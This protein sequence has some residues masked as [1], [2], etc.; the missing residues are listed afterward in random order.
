MNCADN[1]SQM[2]GPNLLKPFTLD[3]RLFM[4]SYDS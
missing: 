3:N 1:F 4:V 2:D